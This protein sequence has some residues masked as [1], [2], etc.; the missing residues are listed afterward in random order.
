VRSLQDL[1]LDPTTRELLMLNGKLDC[2]A[3]KNKH[4]GWR[5]LAK[6]CGFDPGMTPARQVYEDGYYS[7]IFGSNRK[8]P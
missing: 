4:D 7:G 2:E 6:E 3:G 8:E 5:D 1:A